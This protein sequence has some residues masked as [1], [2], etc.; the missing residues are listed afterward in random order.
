MLQVLC[1]HSVLRLVCCTPRKG[2]NSRLQW[3]PLVHT[4]SLSILEPL[5]HR[6]SSWVPAAPRSDLCH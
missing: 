4:Q 5:A 3:T 6:Q 2:W 1:R